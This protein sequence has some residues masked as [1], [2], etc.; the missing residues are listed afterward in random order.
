MADDIISKL[1]EIR[2][3]PP[4][5]RIKRLKEIEEQNKKEIEAA[6]KLL[7]ESQDEIEEEEKEKER[8][9]IPQVRAVDIDMLV[10]EEER[11]IFATKRYVDVKKKPDEEN[12][13][14][15]QLSF[16]KNLE[17]ALS[18]EP[19][20]RLSRSQL[21]EHKQYQARLAEMPSRDLYQM[22]GQLMSEVKQRLDER[23]YLSSQQ[24]QEIETKARDIA[25][26]ALY[27][28]KSSGT[29]EMYK[30][31]RPSEDIR[32]TADITTN[33]MQYIRG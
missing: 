18:E 27:Q 11:R 25:Y 22:A 28:S 4:E 26:A 19:G 31:S 15:K 24:M 1:K 13:E 16:D 9:P 2:N 23:G 7:Q 29:H 5:E 10:S 20:V 30:G 17:E 3:L 21:E 6:H 14:K 33:I 32:K 8:I 12:K